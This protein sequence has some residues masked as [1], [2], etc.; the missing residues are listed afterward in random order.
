MFTGAKLREGGG[1]NAEVPIVFVSDPTSEAEGIDC[2]LRASGYVVVDVPLPML[3]ARVA[4]QHPSVIL[5]D[6]DSHGALDV[7]ARLRELPEADDVHVI[8]LA[9]PGGAVSTLDEAL[10][11]EGSGLATRPI[12]VAEVLRQIASL[13]GSADRVAPVAGEQGAMGPE[14]SPAPAG[15]PSAPSPAGTRA[16]TAS[17]TEQPSFSEPPTPASRI[18]MPKALGLA[19]AVSIELQRLLADAEAR[20]QLPLEEGAVPSPEQEIEAVLPAD[21]LA[22]LDEPLDEEDEPEGS[23]APPPSSPHGLG[24]DRTTD[25]GGSRTTGASTG[26][27][28]TPSTGGASRMTPGPSAAATSAGAAFES[29]SRP[30]LG[31]TDPFSL[32]ASRI[33]LPANGE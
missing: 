17:V 33:T 25:G 29:R 32:Q 10:A 16:S 5:I 2:A 14:G 26:G 31:A 7:V 27:G 12:V 13:S 30:P 6:A 20:V 8:F 1:S 24:R 11:H 9:A 3:I 18:P 23:R 19:P 21:L 22:A 28:A 15:H 4:V